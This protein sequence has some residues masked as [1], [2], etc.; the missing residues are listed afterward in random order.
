MSEK[1]EG[2]IVKEL[3]KRT[4][5]TKIEITKYSDG[6]LTV[7]CDGEKETMIHEAIGYIEIAKFDLIA[8]MN[9]SSPQAMPEMDLV[10]VNL[11]QD[12]F[13]LDTT[14]FL[15]SQGKKIGDPMMIPRAMVEM[16]KDAQKLKRSKT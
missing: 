7:K 6:Q 8:Q 15:K 5:A 13:D 11:T 16:R 2:S 10:E 3:P 1:K 14:G 4:I 9:S 12:D